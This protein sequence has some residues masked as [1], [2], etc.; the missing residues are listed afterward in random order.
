MPHAK[1]VHVLTWPAGRIDGLAE[2]LPQSGR[3]EVDI[4][5]GSSRRTFLERTAQ[6]C[7]IVAEVG[8]GFRVV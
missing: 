5:N 8:G 1:V 7:R 4:L 6:A 3:L 2:L